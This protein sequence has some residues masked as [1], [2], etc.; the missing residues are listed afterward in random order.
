MPVAH[1]TGPF[2]AHVRVQQL[3]FVTIGLLWKVQL[4]NNTVSGNYPVFNKA[5][6]A[7]FA[8]DTHGW[9]GMLDTEEDLYGARRPDDKPVPEK[10]ISTKGS[11]DGQA[12]TEGLFRY[13]GLDFTNDK[14]VK[15]DQMTDYERQLTMEYLHKVAQARGACRSAFGLCSLRA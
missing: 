9:H 10:C 7:V 8:K 12:P 13:T 14:W 2:S 5:D 3:S 11:G 4:G 15:Y 1:P 6:V